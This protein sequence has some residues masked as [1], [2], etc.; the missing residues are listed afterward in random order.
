M[1]ARTQGK[2]MFRRARAEVLALDSLPPD[3]RVRAVH[4]HRRDIAPLEVMQLDPANTADAI[5]PIRARVNRCIRAGESAYLFIDEDLR[6]F[7]VSEAH[8]F[9]A[10]WCQQH[11]A[12]LVGVYSSA[13]GRVQER[14]PEDIS[15]HIQAIAP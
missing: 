15:E 11:A 6:V 3:G 5:A 12:W 2:A 1:S 7:V 10:K 9:C 8:T 14:I 13:R 4:A